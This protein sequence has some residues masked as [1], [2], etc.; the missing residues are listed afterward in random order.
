[1][2]NL[3]IQGPAGSLEAALEMPIDAGAAVAI[4]CHPHPLY[5]GSMNDAVLGLVGEALAEVGVNALRFNFRGV[6]ASQGGFDEGR[7]EVDDLLAVIDWAHAQG[8]GAICL[9]GYSFGAHIVCQA[10]P[11]ASQ[12]ARLLLVAPPTA[13]MDMRLQAPPCPLDVFAGDGDQFVDCDALNRWPGAKMH[14]IPGADH[15]FSTAAAS[16]LEAIRQALRRTSPTRSTAG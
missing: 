6:G 5:G 1:M 8:A 2:E 12:P 3:L 7:G 15:F 16:L 14:L 11:Q 9:A 10:L 4:L 13:A